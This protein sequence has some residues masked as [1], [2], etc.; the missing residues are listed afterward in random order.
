MNEAF[1]ILS[2]Y[3][4]ADNKRQSATKRSSHFNIGDLNRLESELNEAFA[5]VH[6]MDVEKRA[7]HP[8]TFSQL[9]SNL[10]EAYDILHGMGVSK[11][12]DK[13]SF[14]GR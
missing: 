3:G 5:I 13:R 11:R 8:D 1:S 4:V 2:E 10:A 14:D 12:A 9:E 7:Q 6:G